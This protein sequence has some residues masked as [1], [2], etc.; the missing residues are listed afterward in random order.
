MKKAIAIFLAI[1]F[2]FSSSIQIFSEELEDTETVSEETADVSTE[3]ESEVVENLISYSCY[4]DTETQLVNIKGTMNHDAFTSHRN[5]VLVIY[6]VPPGREEHDVLLDENIKP[7]AEAAVSI[8]FAFSFELSNLIER[9]SRYA[10]FMRSPDG[11]YT[12]TT[13]AQYPEVPSQPKKNTSKTAFKGISGNYSPIFSNSN[14]KKV[15][16]PI[17]LDSLISTESTKY[18]FKVEE[19]QIFF[20]TVYLERLD[21][22]MQSLS[23]DE[24]EVYFQFL[25]RP[26]SIFAHRANEGAEYVLPN[27]FKYDNIT[28][29]HAITSFL[30]TRYTSKDGDNISGIIIGKAWDNA[31]KYNSFEN[32]TMDDYVKLCG[33]YT[34]IV[35][36]AAWTVDSNIDIAIS[37]SA[38]GF[39]KDYGCNYHSNY[40]FSAKE[41]AERL[42]KYFDE[43]SYS[44]IPCSIFIEAYSN[45][46]DLT[47]EDLNV[48]I[49]TK[50]E[51]P[52]DKFFIGN[53]KLLSSFF[54]ELAGKYKSATAYYNILWI[55][56]ENITGNL[57]SVA[58][59][60][61][62]YSLFIEKNAI[63]FIVDFSSISTNDEHISELSYIFK[64]IDTDAEYLST[65]NALKFFNENTWE[66]VFNVSDI[67]IK[68]SKEYFSE[69]TLTHLPDNIKGEFC[70]FNF[71]K[72][73]LSTNWYAG[74]GCTDIKIDYSSL[75]IKA[76]HGDFSFL[77]DDTCELIYE[78]T[79]PEN[80]SH[81]PY[82]KMKFDIN[83]QEISP[84][85]EIKFILQNEKQ[86][87][88][89]KVIIKGN[90]RNEVVLNLSSAPDFL[91]LDKV[92]ISIR[93]LDDKVT[94]CSLWLYD[95]V[96][97]SQELDSNDLQKLIQE[98]REKTKQEQNAQA[99]VQ[100][101]ETIIMVSVIIIIAIV[102][103]IVLIL[104]LQRNGKAKRKD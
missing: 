83:S 80:I 5:S 37:F 75:G 49:D 88:E 99:S 84:L 13:K 33:Q 21:L 98:E 55:P 22:Q 95:I 74:T 65:K 100:L 1:I 7:I 92:K 16:L 61:A 63:G 41:L 94:N 93:S 76:L 39:L 27:T 44:G 58:Y 56:N 89:S 4:F 104:L 35:S 46:L 20:N 9:Y 87:F 102:L 60:Y 47:F 59:S 26:N 8:T 14:A 81:T 50:K 57:L 97:Y 66:E 67:G 2:V 64:N 11:E 70:Y 79:Y 3:K 96:G 77:D 73:F 34:S 18:I 71:S 103:G 12:L 69:N 36:N 53:Q 28:L 78:Y 62:F 82:V 15:I 48:G 23:F 19:A 32:A 91:T 86:I 101:L 17:Y 30:T 54:N 85:Y 45:P 52:S 31:P 10:I 42:M 90:Q 51:L 29:L 25:M 68:T 38:D 24:T 40:A 6:A 43:S 72:E